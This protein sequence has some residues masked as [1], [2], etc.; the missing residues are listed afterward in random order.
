MAGLSI[1]HTNKV[2]GNVIVA[3]NQSKITY[4]LRKKE[5]LTTI[6]PTDRETELPGTV[7]IDQAVSLTEN[8]YADA[9]R[10]PVLM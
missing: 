8:T 7:A 10:R 6:K 3:I 1:G 4:L 5:R 9:Q 2:K